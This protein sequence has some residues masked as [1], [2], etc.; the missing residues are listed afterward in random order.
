M[1]D[2][3]PGS[4]GV[5]VTVSGAAEVLSGES[6][7]EPG[8]S[9]TTGGVRAAVTA[10]TDTSETAR[11]GDDDSSFTADTLTASNM[12]ATRAT[13]SSRNGFDSAAR[14]PVSK[15]VVKGRRSRTNARWVNDGSGAD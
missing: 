2:V 11:F 4:V 6:G 15:H 7:A 10:D 1:A 3:G 13:I 9:V 12:T 8:F 5:G 14:S